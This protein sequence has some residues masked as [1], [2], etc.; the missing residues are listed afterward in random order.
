M[1]RSF[2]P[3]RPLLALVVLVSMAAALPFALSPGPATAGAPAA[4]A[5]VTSLPDSLLAR[6]G[7]HRVI[8]VADFRR[9][10]AQILPPTRPD[11]LTPDGAREFLDLMIG[12]EALGEEALKEQWVWTAQESARILGLEDRMVMALALDSALRVTQA[13]HLAAGLDS[14][15]STDLGTLARDKAIEQLNVRFDNALLAR[16]AQ[17]WAAIPKPPADSGIFAALRALGRDPVI[18]ESDM[19]RVAAEAADLRFTVRDLTAYWRRLNPLS[20][21]RIEGAPQVRELI[22]NA[23]YENIL[24]QRAHAQGYRDHVD[25]KRQLAKEAELVAVT[26]YVEREVYA[27]IPVDQA[28][29]EKYYLE[30]S[31]AWDLPP[32][33]R[34]VRFLL[35]DRAQANA[36]LEKLRDPAEVE[37]L[38]AKAAAAGI[39]YYAEYSAETDSALFS[40]GM[41]LGVGGQMGPDSTDGGWSVSSVV[42]ILAGHPR[43]LAEVREL[44]ERALY[45]QE[46][47]RMTRA[48][49][50]HVRSKVPVVT[51]PS[52]L[53]RLVAGGLEAPGRALTGPKA[54]R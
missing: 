6:V 2:G 10:W 50:D 23:M 45:G 20:R 42:E 39:S 34:F 14:L 17:G 9:A 30:N 35:P 25:I 4:L 43:P 22:A 31:K 46:G 54:T 3:L 12:K 8:S 32:R 11:S 28:S 38:T 36:M 47:E 33:V 52:A 53:R 15:S 5:A 27:K 48:L 1:T 26:H 24:R 40:R 29:I 16:L 18:A 7:E 49:L 41:R 51:H 21:P 37:T 44:V 13:G 19:D